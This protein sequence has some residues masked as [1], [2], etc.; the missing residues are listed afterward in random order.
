MAEYHV[1]KGS[2][3][4]TLAAAAAVAKPGDVVVVHGVYNERLSPPPGTTW[5]TAEEE[6]GGLDGGWNGKSVIAKG[7]ERPQVAIS[8]PDVTI[9]GLIIRNVPG[10]GITVGPGGSGATVRN[11]YVENTYQGGFGA[12]GMGKELKNLLVEGNEFYRISRSWAVQERPT[13]VNTNFAFVG[14]TDSE[15]RNNLIHGGYGEGLAIGK[16]SERLHIHH[17]VIHTTQ[18]WLIGINRARECVVEHNIAYQTYDPEYEQADGDQ[19]GG[20]IFGDEYTGDG[21]PGKADRFGHSRG[22]VVRFNVIVGAGTLL[23]VRN[24]NRYNTQL[25]EGTVIANNTFVA[26]AKTQL[27]INIGRNQFKRPSQ[28]KIRDNVIVFDKA[29][30]G[31]VLLRCEEPGIV[32]SGNVW[33]VAPAGR[34]NDRVVPAWALVNANRPIAGTAAGSSFTLDDYRPVAGGPLHGLNVGALAAG[35]DGPE[36]PVEPPPVDEVDWVALMA[37]ADEATAEVVTANMAADR[38]SRVLQRLTNQIEEYR[39]AALGGEE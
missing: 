4:A 35:P 16:D 10:R 8:Q 30:P 17:N 19:P 1:R 24:N 7:D 33:S 15:A 22:N 2:E 27:G 13:N 3:M 38:A 20:I 21:D 12:N 37:L 32:W 31:A 25:D 34:P 39:V 28:G 14:V 29:M 5:R 26:G 11:N 36:P 23:G 9:E 18:H 6:R